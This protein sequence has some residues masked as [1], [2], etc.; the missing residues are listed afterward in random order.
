[1][2][3]EPLI[4]LSPRVGRAPARTVCA[5]PHLLEFAR[6]LVKTGKRVESLSTVLCLAQPTVQSSKN[7]IIRRCPRVEGDGSV[8]GINRVI[9][10]PQSFVSFSLLK[11]R[12]VRLG[13]EFKRLVRVSKRSFGFAFAVVVGAEIHVG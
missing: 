1:M 9:Q 3:P 2:R 8:H 6:F 11:P 13:I 7:V 4:M 10:V 12:P 5:A